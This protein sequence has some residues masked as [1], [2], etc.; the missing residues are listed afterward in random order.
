MDGKD[1]YYKLL[2]VDPG[3]SD[4]EI[5]AAYRKLAFEYHPDRSKDNPA[6]EELMKRVNEAYAVLS[7]PQKRHEY[8][9]LRNQSDTQKG[10]EKTESYDGGFR[11]GDLDSIFK[12][13]DRLFENLFGKPMT[14]EQLSAES[15][16]K[17]REINEES[18]YNKD[19][20]MEILQ[21]YL[22]DLD[23]AQVDQDIDAA[24]YAANR[25]ATLGQRFNIGVEDCP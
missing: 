6:A 20:R 11:F 7:D 14:E 25:I 17:I 13:S 21:G 3:A 12:Q 15:D 22:G 10:F 18:T 2:H 4:Q 9:G 24:N 8:D 1:D 5:K 16:R 23:E 19:K